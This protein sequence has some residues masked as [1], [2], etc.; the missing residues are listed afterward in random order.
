MD[1]ARTLPHHDFPNVTF[2]HIQSSVFAVDFDFLCVLGV[3]PVQ[4]FAFRLSWRSSRLG[5][6][7]PLTLPLSLIRGSG[8]ALPVA[9]TLGF[10]S[11]ITDN[12]FKR[13]NRGEDR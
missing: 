8:F 13:L 1:V 3:L 11:G 6:R 7:T 12:V 5:E 2:H 9:V 10:P 4:D